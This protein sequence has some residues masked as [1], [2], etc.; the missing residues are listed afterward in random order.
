MELALVIII[1]NLV[2][3]LLMGIDKKRA[4]KKQYRISEKTLL[5]SAL[6]FGALGATIGMYVFRHKTKHW[7][8]KF[9][10]PLLLIIQLVGILYYLIK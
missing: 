2:T 3:F 6:L 5:V 1:W 9:G 8:F 10:L 4:K 7:Y